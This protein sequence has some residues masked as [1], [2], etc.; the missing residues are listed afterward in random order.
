L[1][2][3][4]TFWFTGFSSSSPSRFTCIL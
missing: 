2:M 4:A 1:M 3:L